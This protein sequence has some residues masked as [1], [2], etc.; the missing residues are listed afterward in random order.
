MKN[1]KIN[2]DEKV[3]LRPKP[4]SFILADNIFSKCLTRCLFKVH[5][6]PQKSVVLILLWNIYNSATLWHQIFFLL[7]HKML[8]VSFWN[9]AG[10]H[11]Q[12][13]TRIR[14]EH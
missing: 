11:D 10:E 9:P 13:M 1:L 5:S 3:V 14:N 6:A 7:K 12:K 2:N 4:L 8:L